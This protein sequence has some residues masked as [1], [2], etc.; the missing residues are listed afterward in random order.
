MKALLEL[1]KTRRQE[2]ERRLKEADEAYFAAMT[3]RIAQVKV[4]MQQVSLTRA[5]ASSS[6]DDCVVGQESVISLSSDAEMSSPPRPPTDTASSAPAPRPPT[7][8]TSPPPLKRPLKPGQFGAPMPPVG[9]MR[10]SEAPEG[11]C[12]DQTSALLGS[13]IHG[14]LRLREA[15][16]K[17]L[18]PA[19]AS[20]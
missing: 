16:R 11:P 20:L 19:R 15:V 13:A 4:K 18:P 8:A 14:M 5:M 10:A 9:S 1:S 2:Y 17:Q 12:A 3:E 6:D 7:R